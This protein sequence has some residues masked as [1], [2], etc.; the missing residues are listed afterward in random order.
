LRYRSSV[1]MPFI[2]DECR[3]IRLRAFFSYAARKS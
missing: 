2:L 1:E 3:A